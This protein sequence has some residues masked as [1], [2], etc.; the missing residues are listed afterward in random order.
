MLKIIFI[1]CL[2]FLS[3]AVVGA[4]AEKGWRNRI[5]AFLIAFVLIA[6]GLYISTI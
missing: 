3:G 4:A 6:I 5:T 2:I 1:F